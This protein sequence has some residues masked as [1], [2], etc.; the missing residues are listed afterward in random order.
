MSY[1]DNLTIDQIVT[2]LALFL[3]YSAMPTSLKEFD[4][5]VEEA[6]EN[7]GYVTADSS[8]TRSGNSEHFSL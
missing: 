5:W 7:N 1:T 8:M 3:R 4:A 6:N 2:R